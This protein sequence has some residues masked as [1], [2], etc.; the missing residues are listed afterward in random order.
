MIEKYNYNNWLLYGWGSVGAQVNS[1][2]TLFRE[3][4]LRKA[5]KE[6]RKIG[7]AIEEG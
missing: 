4:Y 6:F 2:T 7:F 3:K 1:H 5:A